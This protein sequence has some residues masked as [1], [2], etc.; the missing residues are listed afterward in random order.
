M[1][2]TDPE[3]SAERIAALEAALAEREARILSLETRASGTEAHRAVIYGF[4]Q[5]A[6]SRDDDTGEH[7]QRIRGLVL[8]L[9][10]I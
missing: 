5:L 8:S 10:H 2:K 7:L 1:A 3:H 6:E 4:A 9:I